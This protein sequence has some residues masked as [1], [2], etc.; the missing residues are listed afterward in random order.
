MY[1]NIC[2]DDIGKGTRTH[3]NGSIERGTFVRGKWQAPMLPTV[4]PQALEGTLHLNN[5]IAIQGR[6]LLME[7]TPPSA[8]PAVETAVANEEVVVE[9]EDENEEVVVESEDEAGPSRRSKRKRQSVDRYQPKGWTAG[10]NN[11]HTAGRT[12]DPPDFSFDPTG[13]GDPIAQPRGVCKLP[14]IHGC[15][16]GGP[17]PQCSGYKRDGF[18]VSDDESDDESDDVSN[19]E[20]DDE[21]SSEDESPSGKRKRLRRATR[22]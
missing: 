2:M 21:S 19:D 15:R 4:D 18:V 10:S 1:I 11:G 3:P 12:I 20:S 9:S 7:A 14:P 16:K 5:G 22:A 13:R 17:A 6:F 8:P